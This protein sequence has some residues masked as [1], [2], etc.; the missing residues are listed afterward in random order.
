MLYNF[1][2]QVESQFPVQLLCEVFHISR[3]AYYAYKVGKTYQMSHQQVYQS[4]EV[5]KAFLLHKR[6][7]GT[8]RLVTELQEMGLPL[9]RKKV[10]SFM[11]ME[12]LV[13]IQPKSFVPRTTDSRHGK[14]V[15]PNLLLKTCAPVA[16]N[17]VWVGDITY[18]PLKQGKW[19]Y[20]ATWLDLFSRTIVGW[21]IDNNMEE[22]LII[23]ALQKAFDY[24]MPATGLIV[25][26][27]R[28]GQYVATN[29]KK[30]LNKYNCKQ[31]MSRADDPY[32]NAFAESFFSRLKAETLE[33]GAFLS[34]E[35]AKTEVFDFIEIYYNRKR[36]HS[37]LGNKSPL[38]FEKLYY[39]NNSLNLQ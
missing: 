32:D 9:G 4:A 15:A 22:D 21:Q 39:Q 14:R 23:N 20:L 13:A 35:V 36:R 28:G 17:L 34:I 2:Q 11:K 10:R 37:A 19:A 5:K 8:R 38:N 29:F 31:S 30:L 33:N 7:Y 25:H 12:N 3:S 18:L 26:S 24:R 27:D 1:I 16:P 6:R